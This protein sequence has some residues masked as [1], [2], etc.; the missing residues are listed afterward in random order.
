[1]REQEESTLEVHKSDEEFNYRKFLD[2]W[3]AD[4][5]A[6]NAVI[7]KRY[8]EA[9]ERKAKAI[10][11]RHALVEQRLASQREKRERSLLPE[12]PL[13]VDEDYWTSPHGYRACRERRALIGAG[14]CR[15]AQPPSSK[16]CAH[17]WDRSRAPGCVSM[18]PA[19]G[20]T[21]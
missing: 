17:Y 19:T 20:L 10:L 1:M 6:V 4:P 2:E 12:V 5:E 11:Y 9:V 16:V 21:F 13:T 15:T 3:R 14:L 8:E 7:R 18:H